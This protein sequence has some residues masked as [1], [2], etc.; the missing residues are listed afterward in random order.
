MKDK[1]ALFATIAI[2]LFTVLLMG[3]IYAYQKH[4]TNTLK[5]RTIMGVKFCD[6]GKMVRYNDLYGTGRCEF[7]TDFII[8]PDMKK[9]LLDV[10]GAS[11]IVKYGYQVE[12]QYS[13]VIDT[14]SYF[15]EKVLVYDA[16]AQ[17][18]C[19][20]QKIEMESR[21]AGHSVRIR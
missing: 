2:I 17:H 21:A 10:P 13:V 1:K 18:L 14:A 9:Q 5:S 6:S 7:F 4:E 3:G 20:M 12:P 11:R 8:W 15:F 16:V 19:Y